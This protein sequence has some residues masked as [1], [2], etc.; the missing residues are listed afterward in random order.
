MAPRVVRSLLAAG[1]AMG[2]STLW[3]PA[4]AVFVSSGFD[5]QTFFGNGLFQIDQ[6]CLNNPGIH[7]GLGCQV[8]ASVNI[9]DTSDG[10]TFHV[11]FGSTPLPTSMMRTGAGDITWLT[12]PLIGWEFA[13]SCTGEGCE[14]EPWW[15]EWL[16]NPDDHLQEVLLFTGSCFSGDSGEICRPDVEH[17]SVATHVTFQRVPEPATLSLIALA[18]GLTIPLLRRRRR[19]AR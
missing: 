7:S 12:T 19:Q 8:S 10:D 18:A 2:L 13:Q 3:S 14:T 6:S 5:P 9:T 1:L 4:H 15:I 11:V 17:P 16:F